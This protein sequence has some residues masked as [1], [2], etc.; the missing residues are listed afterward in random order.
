MT[1][2]F[3][4]RHPGAIEWAKQNLLHYD[5]HA[6]H[7]L[8]LSLLQSGDTVVGTLPINLVNQLN[9]SGVGYIHLSLEI[10]P[11]LR[12]VE[13]TA[14]QLRS[15]NASLEKFEVNKL[16]LDAG[17]FFRKGSVNAKN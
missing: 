3:I 17:A 1:T 15:C 8:D 4:T 6:A 11:S 16:P 7:L 12:G 14:E 10:P 13:L 2:Y 5:V 9:Q